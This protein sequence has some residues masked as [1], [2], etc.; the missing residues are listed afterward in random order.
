M[1]ILKLSILGM[2]NAGKSTIVDFLTKGIDSVPKKPPD[3]HPTKNIEKK[4]ILLNEKDIIV[5][6]FG[7]QQM[8]RQDY[9][10]N[11]DKYFHSI[12][13]FYYVV[14]IQD[15]YRVM[16]SSMYFSGILQI[17]KK[18]SPPAEIIVLFHK[19]DPDFDPNIKNVKQQF[20]KLTERVFK[21]IK[22]EITSLDTTIFD[23]NTINTA[24][25]FI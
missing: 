19:T 11:P 12:S 25:S 22:T 2:E 1:S 24:F 3:M 20:L 16:S 23:L 5:W 8:Y 7:G 17:I 21:A 15:Y 10:N 6:D 13:Y 4:K 18:Y 9:M 14:D